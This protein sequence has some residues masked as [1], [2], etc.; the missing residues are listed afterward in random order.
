[1]LIALTVL[2]IV[3]L[4]SMLVYDLTR[5]Q[6]IAVPKTRAEKRREGLAGRRGP[7]PA[8]GQVGRSEE[9]VIRVCDLPET[10]AQVGRDS[11]GAEMKPRSRRLTRRQAREMIDP[12]AMIRAVYRRESSRRGKAFKPGLVVVR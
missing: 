8:G 5:R 11:Q 2:L 9:A 6:R 3:V 12:D 7:V 1:M 10:A 4:I